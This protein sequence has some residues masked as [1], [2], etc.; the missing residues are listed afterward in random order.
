MKRRLGCIKFCTPLFDESFITEVEHI[1]K[2]KCLEQEVLKHLCVREWKLIFVYVILTLNKQVHLYFAQIFS[3]SML[4]CFL[5]LD[6]ILLVSRNFS[7]QF[8]HRNETR[9]EHQVHFSL[10]ENTG[11]CQSQHTTI[12]QLGSHMIFFI[13]EVGLLLPVGTASGRKVFFSFLIRGRRAWRWLLS[14][15][16]RWATRSR[17]DVWWTFTLNRI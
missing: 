14:Q 2:R 8:A 15:C 13:K 3:A 1:I 16:F 11:L 6:S 12:Y 5:L 4:Q 10:C 17:L 9:P 7:M